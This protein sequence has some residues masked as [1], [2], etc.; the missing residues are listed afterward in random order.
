MAT[1]KSG[2]KYGVREMIFDVFLCNFFL[3]FLLVWV[4]VYYVYIMYY[5]VYI[6]LYLVRK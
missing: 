4:Y 6:M 3:Q 2:K 5:Y 1:E